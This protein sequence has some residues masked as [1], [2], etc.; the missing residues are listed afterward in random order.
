MEESD[1]P[2]IGNYS[3]GYIYV[4]DYGDGKKFKIGMTNGKV[5]TRFRQIANTSVLMP[6]HL[7]MEAFVYNARQVENLLHLKFEP[8]HIRGEWFELKLMDLVELYQTLSLLGTPAV[9]DH[10]FSFIPEDI[11]RL[12][13]LADVYV[14][15]PPFDKKEYRISIEDIRSVYNS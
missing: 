15:F 4:I 10:W 5:E 12:R 6:M 9:H 1:L 11:H 7:V 8:K 2:T 14:N 13:E 3:P